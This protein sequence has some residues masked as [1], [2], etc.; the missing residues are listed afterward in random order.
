MTRA[1]RFAA[2]A[3]QIMPHMDDLCELPSNVDSWDYID[4]IM[5][6]K[7]EY[8]GGMAAVIMALCK[9]DEAKANMSSTESMSAFINELAGSTK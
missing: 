5:F 9:A 6:D 3:K 7:G 2:K 4:E 1:R 8:I